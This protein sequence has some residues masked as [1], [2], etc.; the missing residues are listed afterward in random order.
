MVKIAEDLSRASHR[1]VY[2]RNLPA[3]LL[4]LTSTSTA[5]RIHVGRALSEPKVCL[6]VQ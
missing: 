3:G 5:S 1:F 6:I 4:S 2:L